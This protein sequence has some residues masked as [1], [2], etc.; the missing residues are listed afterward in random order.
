M[1]TRGEVKILTELQ[2]QEPPLST[3][4]GRFYKIYL[5]EKIMLKPC[6][7]KLLNLH[8]KIKL[9]EGIQGY[10]GLL[11]EILEEPLALKNSKPI[12]LETCNKTVKIELTN[13][14]F[15]CT[16]TISKNEEIVRLFLLHN[17]HKILAS[18]Y[19]KNRNSK[20]PQFSVN[21]KFYIIYSPTKFKLR[22]CESIMLDLRFKTKL[23]G[24][25]QG[26]ISLLPSLILQ[27]L[28]IENH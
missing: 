19:N 23:P 2:L 13:I 10:I 17:L 28:T 21:D 25:V 27:G 26:I 15:Q 7:S 24:N 16:T 6:K 1:E 18:R 3:N 5:P 4:S 8:F 11:L 9:P 20:R 22:P 14:N 12:T